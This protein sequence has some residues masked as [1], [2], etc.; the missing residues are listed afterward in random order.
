MTKPPPS[1]EADLLPRVTVRLRRDDERETFDR[2]L[3]NR[4][5]LASACLAGPTLRYVA[6]LDGQW[7]ALITFS[8]P[9]LPLKA[10]ERWIGRSRR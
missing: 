7:V 1:G 10:H 9:A 4:H 3:E 5:Y 8:A 6:E 2:L